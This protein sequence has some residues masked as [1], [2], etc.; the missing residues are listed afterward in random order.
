MVKL[1][2][3]V[4]CGGFFGTIFRFGISR[5]FQVNITS[6]FPW[7]TFIDY[8]VTLEKTNVLLYKPGKKR[9]LDS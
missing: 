1:L 9:F 7:G 3:I 2:L 4:G 6:V 8:L 5:Y